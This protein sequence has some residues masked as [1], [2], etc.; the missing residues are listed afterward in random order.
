MTEDRGAGEPERG[1]EMA[2][3]NEPALVRT[4][5]GRVADASAAKDDG[6][7]GALCHVNH[8]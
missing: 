8:G 3:A 1:G 4:K 5:A 6:R 2:E 7:P